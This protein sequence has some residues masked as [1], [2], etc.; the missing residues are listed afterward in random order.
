MSGTMKT[1]LQKKTSKGGT[2]EIIDVDVFICSPVARALSR[3]LADEG[4]SL[5]NRDN[6]LVV[7]MCSRFMV[8]NSYRI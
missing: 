5:M 2:W 1:V 3:V 4:H 8:V 6:M 7:V